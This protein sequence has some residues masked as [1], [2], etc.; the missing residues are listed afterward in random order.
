MARVV[1]HVGSHKT[2]ST[3]IQHALAENRALLASHGLIYPFLQHS[4]PAHHGLMTRWNPDLAQ[5][6]P[7]DGAEAAWRDIARR[8]ARSPGTLVLSSEEF[9]RAHGAHA[10]D[11]AWIRDALA[12][13]E[14]I[15]V[16]CLLRDQISFVQSAYL[17]HCKKVARPAGRERRLSPWDRYVQRALG[18]GTASGL[19]LDYNLLYDRLLE[20]F[21]PERIHLIPYARAQARPQGVVAAVLERAGCALDPARLTVS[22]GGRLNVTSD[23]LSVWAAAQV[24]AP[25][26]PPD[27]LVERAREIVGRLQD[28]PTTLYT[29]Q[30]TRAMKKRFG[31][32]N[33]RL[34]GRLAGRDPDF[35]LPWPRL[36]NALRR[37]R[38]DGEFWLAMARQLHGCT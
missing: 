23:P 15:D 32:A 7:K 4:E 6:R 11:F 5:Y 25:Y 37:D 3:A 24:S 34:A 38:I 22:S 12:E 30:E 31:R 9:S 1:L 10:T 19:T 18:V 16:V 20:V 2:G 26:A 8:H 29:Q 36:K 33:E 13:F 27:S 17:Q 28:G 21:A 14:S 35:A